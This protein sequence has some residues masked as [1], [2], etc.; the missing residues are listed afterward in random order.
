VDH[1]LNW[2]KVPHYSH[3]KE[4]PP[5][6]DY[7]PYNDGFHGTNSFGQSAPLKSGAVGLARDPYLGV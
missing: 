4:E 3:P 5:K 6:L 2:K 1:A 7:A